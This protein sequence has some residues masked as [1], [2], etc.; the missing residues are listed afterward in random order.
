M[1][2]TMKLPVSEIKTNCE[3]CVYAEFDELDQVGC[4][5]GRLDK[6][7]EL[8]AANLHKDENRSW[9]L[10][11]RFCNLY[12]EKEQNLE[13]AKN[14]IM[15]RFGITVYDHQEKYSNVAIESLKN[16]PYVKGKYKIVISSKHNT[17][18]SDLF[19]YVNYFNKV[20]KIRCDLSVELT[21]EKS[22][23]DYNACS[24]HIHCTHIVKINSD[25]EMP[26]GFLS[27]VNDSINNQ[28]EQVMLYEC[29]GVSVIPLWYIN[30]NYL[31]YNDFD[32]MLDDLRQLSIQNNMYRKYER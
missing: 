3:K 20:E 8:G 25:V 29:D 7:N 13:D 27:Y 26:S 9:Y 15:L 18:A 6:F 10:L 23:I 22:I 32:I 17:K 31:N 2:C 30:N 5:T 16:Y 24:K 1:G 4:K 21:D 11:K 28:L 12:R 19:N 14:Q